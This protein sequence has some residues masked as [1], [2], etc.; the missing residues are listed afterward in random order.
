MFKRFNLS[1]FDSAIMAMGVSLIAIGTYYYQVDMDSMLSSSSG[2]VVGRLI[3]GRGNQKRIG[4]LFW[5]PLNRDA[6]IWNGDKIFA[7]QDEQINIELIKSKAVVNV[8]KK[9]LV[10]ITEN[11]ND[12]VLN[13]DRGQI[14]ISSGP[15]DVSF[16]IRSSTGLSKSIKVKPK[17]VINLKKIDDNTLLDVKEGKADLLLNQGQANI[18]VGTNDLVRVSSS[19]LEKVKMNNLVKTANIDP[20]VE[21][22]INL[23]SN[24]FEGETAEIYESLGSKPIKSEVIKNGEINIDDISPGSYFVK[25]ANSQLL[26]RIQIKE[27]R[28]ISVDVSHIKSDVLQGEKIDFKW[29]NP[30]GH[31][32]EVNITSPAGEVFRK[33]TTSD[34]L[35]FYPQESGEHNISVVP[36]KQVGASEVPILK[37]ALDQEIKND[38]FVA[39]KVLS[40][41]V[42]TLESKSDVKRAASRNVTVLS[43]S[44]GITFQKRDL[45]NV[46]AKT[47]DLT[48]DFFDQNRKIKILGVKEGLIKDGDKQQIAR[49]RFLSGQGKEEVEL[50]ERSNIDKNIPA[51]RKAKTYDDKG[52]KVEELVARY[53]SKGVI[54][55]VTLFKGNKKYDQFYE[56]GKVSKESKEYG[57]EISP[58]ILAVAA[59]FVSK[60]ALTPQKI[61]AI[62][63]TA[64]Y[65]PL[66]TTSGKQFSI[67]L[68]SPVSIKNN[69]DEIDA[70]DNYIKKIEIESQAKGEVRYELMA[71]NRSIIKSGVIKGADLS[72]K[73]L[74]SGDY[75]LNFFQGQKGQ[76]IGNSKINVAPRI[77][78]IAVNP[79]MIKKMGA[80]FELPLKWN[81]PVE[82]NIVEVFT[83]GS[84]TPIISKPVRGNS[85]SVK[86]PNV[87]DLTWRVR[88]SISSV[89]PSRKSKIAPPELIK[90]LPVPAP[91]VMKFKK[92]YGGC[93]SFDLPK[94]VNSTRYFI[95][96]YENAAR[97]KMVFNRWLENPSVCWQSSRHGKYF[98]RYKYFDSWNRQSSFS[99]MGEI[100]F[101]ISPLT[102]F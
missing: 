12:L 26:D 94:I 85:V 60:R 4:N 57:K 34:Q 33:V 77:S 80:E 16:K 81:S 86:V 54:S 63:Q 92:D 53:D 56:N 69:I 101:P 30:K 20:L 66:A 87:D 39:D 50:Y 67:S 59:A 64:R 17:S 9:S 5:L 19:N 55:S 99:K 65:V 32:V 1:H 49:T 29:D 18:S 40:K 28:P 23:V 73:N 93:Y 43:T 96:V 6:Q 91:I 2:N 25:I 3:D 102:E 52:R 97:T 41:I 84:D 48:F 24:K 37:E 78:N 62:A 98:Y 22:N 38:L 88:G 45:K 89:L 15:K 68:D 14:S 44:N 83:K 36:V 100:I 42:K 51:L 90:E 61:G 11:Q 76:K 46:K 72:F 79:S 71:D 82:D 35:A 7:N 75:Q 74:E 31:T 10:V 95:E 8:P 58:S 47:S 21:Q 70:R 13:L 27:Y